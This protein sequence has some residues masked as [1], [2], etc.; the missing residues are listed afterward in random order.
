MVVHQFTEPGRYHVGVHRG[1]RTVADAEFEV[2][3]SGPM[4]INIDL[5]DIARRNPRQGDCE[6]KTAHSEPP[7][8]SPTGYVLFHASTGDGYS[9][10][11]A[12]GNEKVV[13]DSTKLGK[14]DLYAT[15]I[16]EPGKYTINNAAGTAKGEIVVTLNAE[17][18]KALK[19]LDP[20]YV[21]TSGRA[22]S[23]AKFRVASSQG[24]VFRV[25]DQARIVITRQGNR[26]ARERKSVLQWRKPLAP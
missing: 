5:G 2:D 19:G 22:F 16:L 11:V 24:V 4:Q 7:K 25:K 20:V 1:G 13:F 17:D 18:I 15:S 10:T 8:V 6:C 3:P 21:E 23:P 12:A 14:G 26:A 9:A